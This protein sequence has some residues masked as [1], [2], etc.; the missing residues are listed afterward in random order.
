MRI[1]LTLMLTPLSS[2]WQLLQQQLLLLWIAPCQVPLGL[3]SLLGTGRART[4]GPIAPITDLRTA[5]G[6]AVSAVTEHV[7]GLCRQL[8]DGARSHDVH[9]FELQCMAVAVAAGYAS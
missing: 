2:P 8:A 6:A 7:V 3:R 5:F 9:W 4:C 1:L